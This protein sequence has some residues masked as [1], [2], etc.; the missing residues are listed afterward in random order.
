VSAVSLRARFERFPATVKGAFVLR[1][2]DKDPH[3]VVVREA[4][5][6]AVGGGSHPI[7][8]ASVT[9]DVA[10]KKD[11]FVP[12]ELQVSDLAPGWYGFEC[13]LEVDGRPATY[14]GGKRFSVAWPRATVRRGLIRVGRELELQGARIR[15]EQVE[16]RSDTIRI[17]LVVTPPEPVSV[18][19]SADGTRIE[20]LDVEADEA[21]GRVGVV[22]CPLF[23]THKVLRVE[24]GSGGRGA[25]C[26]FDV[27][28]P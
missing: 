4:R 26:A 3:Q 27:R 22:A 10:P 14:P 12:F 5:V 24:L 13:D 21:T 8:M 16:C 18:T 17:G 28:L 7:P 25:E 15:V 23:R 2:E 9:L 6:V 20:L 1:G 11:L 19:L